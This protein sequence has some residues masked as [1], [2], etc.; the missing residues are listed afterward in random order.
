MGLDD[1]HP[2]DND[3]KSGR[4]QVMGLALH[5]RSLLEALVHHWSF[6]FFDGRRIWLGSCVPKLRGRHLGHLPAP[7]RVLQAGALGLKSR[8]ESMGHRVGKEAMA[9]ADA[10]ADPKAHPKTGRLRW[11]LEGDQEETWRLPA[12]SLAFQL[13]APFRGDFSISPTSETLR[14]SEESPQKLSIRSPI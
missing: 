3:W 13:F 7:E 5:Q 12:I 4:P 11:F 1:C 6:F 10:S 9:P 14:G 2:F 8:R